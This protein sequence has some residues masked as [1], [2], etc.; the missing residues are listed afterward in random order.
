MNKLRNELTKLDQMGLK[1]ICEALL[2]LDNW[3]RRSEALSKYLAPLVRNHVAIYG[4]TV[5]ETQPTNSILN[6]SI[7]R[8][9]L[10]QYPA[11]RAYLMREDEVEA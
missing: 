11:I 8:E 7:S 2:G 4:N 3:D 1:S 9:S 6:R 10:S 5:H